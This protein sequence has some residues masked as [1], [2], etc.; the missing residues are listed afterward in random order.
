MVSS[1]HAELLESF[2][3]WAIADANVRSAVLF[4]SRARQHSAPA[5]ADTWSDIDL[6]LIC[7]APTRLESLDWQ[8]FIS[9]HRL[10][11]AVVRPASSGVKKITLLFADGEAD[12]IVVPLAKMR[13]AR[14]AVQLGLHRRWEFLAGMLNNMA[15]IMSGGYRFLKGETAWGTFYG[16]V[17]GEMPGFRLADSRIRTMADIFLCDL[18]SVMQKI[19]RG[20]LVA[21]QRMLHR[22]VLETNIELLHELRL[23]EGRG[24]FQQARRVEKLVPAEELACI[25]VDARLQRA[26]LRTAAWKALTGLQTLMARL[27]PAWRAPEGVVVLIRQ[28]AQ[29]TP[30]RSA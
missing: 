9:G 5:A 6:H 19:A 10:E 26:E 4:G 3:R 18:L 23:R 20:E 28:A 16:R 24:T 2:S 13:L 22:T 12:L 25:Q 11:L 15:T 8:R 21:A 30:H 1:D 29:D 14:M 27:V 7:D 17:V